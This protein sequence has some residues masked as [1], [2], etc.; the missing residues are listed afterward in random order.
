MS[1]KFQEWS[2]VNGVR[3]KVSSTYHPEADRQSERK[4]KHISE[5]FA[6]AQLEGHNCITAGSKNQANVNARQNKSR[7]ESPFFT[8]YGF[9]PKLCSSEL[10][11]P[12]PIYSD[13]AKRFYQ[14]A[15]KLTK[16]EYDQIIQANTHRRVAPDYKINDQVILCTKNL[17]AAFH[18]SK[19]APKWIGPFKIT[20][21]IPWSQNVSLDPSELPYLQYITNSFHTSLIKLYIP[22]NDVKFTSRNLHKPGPVEGDR[23]EVEQVLQFTF[24]PGTRQPQ[25]F[26]KWK[27]YEHKDNSCINAEDIDKQQKADHWLHGNKSHTYKLGKSGKSSQAK[28]KRVETRRQI[29]EERVRVLKGVK[30]DYEEPEFSAQAL[31]YTYLDDHIDRREGYVRVILRK[32]SHLHFN[33]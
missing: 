18:Q 4:N 14:A 23:W 30:P 3:H 15:E 5:M 28:L 7:A 24:K 20:N 2:L 1:G 21:F 8:L 32:R 31:F 16:A 27:G 33:W 9:Q 19:L 12:I 22:N 29:H 17:P 11:H 25:Y 13:P 6:A 10:P 26:V